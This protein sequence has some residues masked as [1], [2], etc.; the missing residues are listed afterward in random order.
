[1]ITI[2]NL[3][4]TY[5]ALTAVSIETLSI[6]AGQ[7][8]GLVGNNGAGKTTLFR[9]ILDL[10][11]PTGGSITSKQ[12]KV[13]QDESW[14]TYTGAYLDEGFLIG[15]LTP[16]EYFYFI[17]SLH[18]LNKA[19]VNERLKPYEDF[20]KGEVRHVKKYI[21]DLSK[22]N[23]KKVGIVAALLIEPEIIILDEPFANLDPGTQI[24]LKNV[25]KTFH[26]K[27][28]ATLIIS[29]HDLSHITEVCQRIV[30]LEKGIPVKDLATTP[31]TLRELEAYFS[32]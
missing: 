3:K 9:M 29:S 28:K 4:K 19:E 26:E 22:G 16:D 1:M 25:L 30:I 17:G 7:T 6:P 13:A 21:R 24:G 32:A 11:R 10:I 2:E 12:I 27:H 20:F 23:Q 18:Q 8:F 14:K 31:S 5:G 15:Y